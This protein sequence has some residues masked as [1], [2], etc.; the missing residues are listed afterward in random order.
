M[1]KKHFSGKKSV[2]EIRVS[3]DCPAVFTRVDWQTGCTPPYPLQLLTNT[4][5]VAVLFCL[6]V[7]GKTSPLTGRHRMLLV[8]G[9]GRILGQIPSKPN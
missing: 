3:P 1:V 5:C 9:G 6:D 2:T 4:L 7:I 8:L